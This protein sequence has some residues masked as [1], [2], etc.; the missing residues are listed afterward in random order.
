[1]VPIGGSSTKSVLS[2][3][4]I[5]YTKSRNQLLHRKY[6]SYETGCISQV[7]RFKKKKKN[8]NRSQK[9]VGLKK[10]YFLGHPNSGSCV[11]NAE[12]LLQYLLSVYKIL[13]P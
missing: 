5:V 6:L 13:I 10:A 12:T 7:Y 4:W 8:L 3:R 1:M 2:D 11:Q 9:D